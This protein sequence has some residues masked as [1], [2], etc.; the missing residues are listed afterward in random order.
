MKYY[1]LL[2]IGILISACLAGTAQTKLNIADRVAM[3]N[4]MGATN[5]NGLSRIAPDKKVELLVRF[6]DQA[7][8]ERLRAKGAE[9]VDTYGKEIAVITVSADQAQNALDTRGIKSARISRKMHLTNNRGHVASGAPN[10]WKGT[11]LPQGYDGS[12]VVVGIYDTGIDAN[13]LH[14]SDNNGNS[15]VKAIYEYPDGK[16][17][18]NEYT[19]PEQIALFKTD[20]RNQCHGTHVLGTMTGAFCLEG[21]TDY[22]GVAPGAQIIITTGQGYDGQILDA[23]KRVGEY[24]RA[25]GLPTV[26]NLSWGDNIGPHDGTDEFVKALNDLAD[27]YDMV[28]ACAAGNERND[29]IAI[30]KDLTET[31]TIAQTMLIGGTSSSYTANQGYGPVQV[32]TTDDTP[33]TVYLDVMRNTNPYNPLYTLT[34]QPGE[35]KYLANGYRIYNYVTPDDNIEIIDS[36]TN[37]Q[38]YYTNSF[39]GGYVG[40]NSING[41][42]CADLYSYLNSNSSTSV[43]IRLRVEGKPGQRIFIYTDDSRYQRFGRG[44]MVDIDVPDGNGTNSNMAS[45]P[46]TMSV[47]S[48]VIT[49]IQSS[50]YP[51]GTVGDM[52]YF[53]SYGPTPDGRYVP[54]LTAPG[55]VIVSARNSH[56]SSSYSYSVYTSQKDPITGKT[57][58][59]TTMSGTSQATPN[60]AGCAA[61]IRQ[62]VPDYSYRE[63]IDLLKDNCTEPHFDNDGWGNGL[64]NAHKAA[65]AAA[66]LSGI[67]GNN[68]D[69]RNMITI[70]RNSSEWLVTVPSA[71]DFGVEIYNPGGVCVKKVSCQGAQATINLS[72][73]PNG[74]YLMKVSSQSVSKTEK[75][76]L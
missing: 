19:T 50:G 31:D 73:L 72:G 51:N 10:V 5:D 71:S 37:F 21:K 14:F 12:N 59:F 57:A 1:R 29:P 7:T 44:G 35:E 23:V 26:M 40:I 63:V 58:E 76:F 24:G 47:G 30:V 69:T 33:F 39:V 48:Y 75:I 9:I 13:H 66:S 70:R 61:L 43:Y 32:W 45:G 36:D 20:D 62:I 56:L 34:F 53:S 55:Q 27:E 22:R 68:A 54:D 67:S 52:S 28:I 74:I 38:K 8:L 60:A 11:D 18:P 41:R 65:V 17:I 49:N 64:I 2:S 6:S 3:L 15:R 25:N 16:S 42:Y 4:S 46:N